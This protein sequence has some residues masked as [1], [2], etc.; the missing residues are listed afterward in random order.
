MGSVCS[1]VSHK[2]NQEIELSSK[3]THPVIEHFQYAK[4]IV[5]NSRIYQM[6]CKHAFEYG[7]DCKN[8]LPP[9]SLIQYYE[10][11][12][13]FYIQIKSLN[14]PLGRRDIYDRF[15]LDQRFWIVHQT[16]YSL[17][18]T[19]YVACKFAARGLSLCAAVNSHVYAW[20]VFG[21]DSSLGST[22]ETIQRFSKNTKKEVEARR[23]T[24][25][26]M[27]RVKDPVENHISHSMPTAPTNNVGSD[28]SSTD[29][30]NS[31]ASE[32]LLLATVE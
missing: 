13:S 5:D 27:K 26:I 24:T 12:K 7:N 28:N 22:S 2:R 8:I 15:I 3:K 23:T 32:P 20:N 25:V 1:C 18:T 10:E 31:N 14:G 6:E 4:N 21:S 29:D 17:C 9:E 30:D 11:V 19:D 16:H